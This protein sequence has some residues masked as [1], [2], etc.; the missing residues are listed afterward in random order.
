MWVYNPQ[1]KNHC[2]KD[3]F[4]K[5]LNYIFLTWTSEIDYSPKNILRPCQ[6]WNKLKI[7]LTKYNSAV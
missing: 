5:N 7:I 1:A 4:P 2:C 3:E 6:F